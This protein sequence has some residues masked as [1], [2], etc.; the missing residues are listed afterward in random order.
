MW[1]HLHQQFHQARVSSY[2]TACRGSTYCHTGANCSLD[3]P[4]NDG[5]EEQFLGLKRVAN[6]YR[7]L[8]RQLLCRINL[9]SVNKESV[10]CLYVG[11]LEVC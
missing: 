11:E 2:L 8:S 9:D 6:T 4:T 5:M 10:D 3:K 7:V 1:T